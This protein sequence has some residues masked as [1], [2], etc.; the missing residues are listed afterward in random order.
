MHFECKCCEAKSGANLEKRKCVQLS[1]TSY[2]DK[3]NTDAEI[4]QLIKT[5][6]QICYN[7]QLQN[8]M[9][10]GESIGCSMY[11]RIIL[12]YLYIEKSPYFVKI[13]S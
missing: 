7:H 10:K 13:D 6:M 9:W 2:Y 1:R 11:Y 5:I 4:S 3:I 8:I 12:E